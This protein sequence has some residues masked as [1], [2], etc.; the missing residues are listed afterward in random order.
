MTSLT[1]FSLFIFFLNSCSTTKID[2]FYFDIYKDLIFGKSKVD[3]TELNIDYSYVNISY[4]KLEAIFVLSGIDSD[5]VELWVGSD[6]SRI[7]TYKGLIVRTV[8]LDNDFRIEN[9]VNS[10]IQQHPRTAYQSFVSLIDP[11]LLFI[12]TETKL[13]SVTSSN[14]CHK[15]VLYERQFVNLGFNQRLDFCFDKNE[16]IHS[17]SQSL[18]PGGEKYIMRFH[19]QYDNGTS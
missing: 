3:F 19:Y 11:E 9:I 16:V 18:E 4:G 13:I 8:G 12:K 14:T 15:K 17:S 10:V 5:G 7:W 2:T 6:R 1:R